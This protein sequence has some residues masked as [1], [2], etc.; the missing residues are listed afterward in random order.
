MAVRVAWGT[1]AIIRLSGILGAQSPG[2]GA[3]NL[4]RSLSTACERFS[5]FSLRDAAGPQ[6]SPWPQTG[7]CHVCKRG[8]N[9]RQWA[10][11][12]L[13]ERFRVQHM[14]QTR[15]AGALFRGSVPSTFVLHGH[16][17]GSNPLE[18][19]VGDSKDWRI[20][21]QS[22]THR[23]GPQ[24]SR[25]LLFVTCVETWSARSRYAKYA[26]LGGCRDWVRHS[27]WTFHIFLEYLDLFGQ[28][29]ASLERHLPLFPSPSGSTL[30]ERD[31][32]TAYCHRKGGHRQHQTWRSRQGPGAVQRTCVPCHWIGVAL[33]NFEVEVP[34]S[35]F[36]AWWSQS[37]HHSRPQLS[38]AQANRVCVYRFTSILR[39][40]GASRCGRWGLHFH[41]EH[42]WWFVARCS[43]PCLAYTRGGPEG[44]VG[45]HGGQFCQYTMWS[46]V[47]CQFTPCVSQFVSCR[48]GSL[49]RGFFGASWWVSPRNMVRPRAD[50]SFYAY[51]ERRAGSCGAQVGYRNISDRDTA[52]FASLEWRW[53]CP[54]G[55]QSRPARAD[56]YHTPTATQ[57][58]MGT[59][60]GVPRAQ[61]MEER[62][63]PVSLFSTTAT[64]FTQHYDLVRHCTSAKSDE[65]MN[66]RRSM[67]TWI[68]LD[69]YYWQSGLMNETTDW[70][71]EG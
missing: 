55:R 40:A 4:S 29:F 3:S 8:H 17:Q 32:V 60:S 44:V 39:W 9:S 66:D 61:S 21:S 69:R 45:G 58:D 68:A 37:H 14:L 51:A 15:L 35:M 22:F 25:N 18:R 63:Y 30:L 1:A 62:S 26:L 28:E 50:V 67:T 42:S 41:S 13:K 7:R 57:M 65:D 64:T 2:L 11:H 20:S 33:Q 31:V 54:H 10:G 56:C 12:P 52:W 23:N 24:S 27:A 49:P 19:M 6:S 36:C 43:Q 48:A 34:R 38:T 46:C 47:A 5:R 16:C 59:T 70:K 53:A 71:W